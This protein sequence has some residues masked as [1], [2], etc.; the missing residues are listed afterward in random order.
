MVTRAAVLRELGL[1]RPY[2]ESRPFSVEEVELAD[3]GPHEVRVR[4]GAAGLCHSDLSVVDGSRPRPMPMVL[5]HEA[6]GTVEAIGSGV[7]DLAPGD[8]VVFSF[9]PMC[10]RCAPCLTGRPVLC[11]PGTVANLDGTL[12]GGVRRLADAAGAP[13]NHH[14]GVSAFAEH[15]VCSDASLVRIGPELPFAE[16]ALLGCALL[17]GVGAV[18]NTAQAG[19]GTSAAVFGLG[20][21]GLSVVMGAAMAG[22]HPIVAVDMVPDKLERAGRLGAT[23]TVAAGPDAVGEV[24]ELTAGGAEFAFEAVGSAAVLAQAY[25]ATRRGGTTVTVGLPGPEQML[26]IPAISLVA[27]ERR[28]LGSFMGSSVPQRDIPRLIALRRSGALDLG[29][30]TTGHI[31]LEEVNAGFEALAG[32]EAVRQVIVF[33]GEAGA[34]T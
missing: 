24:V 12:L 33:G 28:L 5:G 7:R 23:H 14:L 1:P 10:G 21:V 2:A 30:L 3:P 11:E 32:G 26:S 13:V 17:T 6:A 15:A 34:G 25:A 20:G 18:V 8:R 9:I 22:C 27:H 16:A 31:A 19:P 4:I 29:E